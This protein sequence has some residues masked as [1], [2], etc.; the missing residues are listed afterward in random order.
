MK[1]L[2][3]HHKNIIN[4]KIKILIK[5]FAFP[6]FKNFEKVIIIFYFLLLPTP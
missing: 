6:N 4:L 2:D 3:T 1:F 5:M